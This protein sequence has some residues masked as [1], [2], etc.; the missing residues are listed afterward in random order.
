MFVELSEVDLIYKLF[1]YENENYKILIFRI[2]HST[3]LYYTIIDKLTHQQIIS[4]K[5]YNQLDESKIGIDEIYF[6]EYLSESVLIK[7]ILFHDMT[8]QKATIILNN[9][10]IQFKNINT[11]IVNNDNII[12]ISDYL[13]V[14]YDIEKSK[15][16]IKITETINEDKPTLKLKIDS[17]FKILNFK[18]SINQTYKVSFN[19]IIIKYS[20]NFISF[21]KDLYSV[22]IIYCD[23][24]LNFSQS[25]ILTKFYS[26]SINKPK[27]IIDDVL[28]DVD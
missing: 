12:N 27:M 1:E 3:D 17:D 9:Y 6:Y 11:E 20:K 25:L 8:F 2:E 13:V 28:E 7:R 14:S 26:S 21:I 16:Y 24:Y 19:K 15:N 22:N 5:I 23:D 4:Y 10:I 18:Q